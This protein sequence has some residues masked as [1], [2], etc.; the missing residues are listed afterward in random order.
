MAVNAPRL[1]IQ[2]FA[3]SAFFPGIAGGLYAY[4]LTYI[5]PD[6][7]FN[8]NISILIVLMALFGGGASWMGPVLGAVAL[9]VINEGLSTFVKAELARIIYGCLFIVVIIFMPNGVIAFL[10]EKMRRTSVPHEISSP[11]A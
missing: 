4:Y 6:I 11:S 10:G 1:K 9:T 7:V 5:H 3:L 2:A 8:V